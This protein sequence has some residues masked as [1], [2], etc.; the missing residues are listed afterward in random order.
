MHQTSPSKETEAVLEED[1]N[2]QTLG[3]GGRWIESTLTS[4]SRSNFDK[5]DVMKDGEKLQRS[6]GPNPD[7]RQTPPA[8]QPPT[9]KNQSVTGSRHGGEPNNTQQTSDE[10][11]RFHASTRVHPSHDDRGRKKA[12]Q[13]K[14]LGLS[15]SGKNYNYQ[16]LHMLATDLQPRQRSR[17]HRL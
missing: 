12:C 14:G 3:P 5:S 8:E 2:S 16:K 7:T 9:W 1:E 15:S 17:H 13:T 10:R 6:V 11:P 4:G